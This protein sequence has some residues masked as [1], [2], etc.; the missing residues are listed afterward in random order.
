MQLL[1]N[2]VWEVLH[3]FEGHA[4]G[5]YRL[6]E[7]YGEAGLVVLFDLNDFSQTMRPTSISLA[8]FESAI[9]DGVVVQGEYELPRAKLLSDE[10]LFESHKKRRDQKYLLIHELVND[11]EFL[12]RLVSSGKSMEITAYAQRLGIKNNVMIYRA[13]TDYWRYGQTPNAFNPNYQNSGGPGKQ[14]QSTGVPRGRPKQQPVY[15]FQARSIHTVTEKDKNNIRKTIK[16]FFIKGNTVKVTKLY[17]KFLDKHYFNELQLAKAERRVPGVPSVNQF[18]YW[19]KQLFDVVNDEKDRIGETRWDMNNRGMT[20]G[21]SEHVSAPGDCFEIDATVADVFV[22]SK[23]N[24][25]HVLGRPVIYVVVDQASR[26]VVGLF[27]DIVYAS[28]DAAKQAL[29]NAFLPKKSFC[30]HYGIEI[31]EED[32]PC[33]HMPRSL[34]CDR[35][36]MIHS[37]PEV[38]SR[39]L[40]IKLDFA[41]PTRA[42]WKSVVERRFGIANDE[43]IHELKGTTNGKPK[44]RMDPDPK[45]SALHT[46]DEVFQILIKG[47]IKFN[48]HRFIDDLITPELI[49][50]DLEA[51]PLNYWNDRVSRHLDSLTIVDEEQAKAELLRA[52][53]AQITSRGIR[54]GDMFYSCKTAEDENWFAIARY[55]GESSID[56][57]IDD[58]NSSEIYVRKDVRSPLLLCHLLPREKLYADI[59]RAEVVWLDEWKREKKETGSDLYGR[60][61]HTGDVEDMR[62]NALKDRKDSVGSFAKSPNKV[63]DI[64]KAREEELRRTKSTN[65][66]DV[67]SEQNRQTPK[68]TET[69][70]K[71]SLIE[72]VLDDDEG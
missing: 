57:R 2:S 28:W 68:K 30:E 9:E 45:E 18:R 44:T 37:Q 26:M 21:V 11:Q 48:K 70:Y 54:V 17:E 31:D 59:H 55:Q 65:G 33:H 47:F 24:R 27:V 40:G 35:G 16:R 51:T 52:G 8:A 61:S 53:K 13:L 23:Y 15:S 69:M 14:K 3:Q 6:L 7:L 72:N 50:K 10:E 66:A 29:L 5:L 41:S 60:V 63:K 38:H 19:F 39:P 58:S 12:K 71:L 43:T 32:W 36:E 34:L 22:V 25:S 56:A 49:E 20:S 46:V 42:D 1:R 62:K 4:E 67:K 64:A